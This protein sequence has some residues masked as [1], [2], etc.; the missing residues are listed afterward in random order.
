MKRK[1]LDIIK[2]KTGIT[3]DDLDNDST[4][5]IKTKSP[6]YAL[7]ARARVIDNL[8]KEDEADISIQSCIDL[9]NPIKD[10][11]SLLPDSG[12]AQIIKDESLYRIKAASEALTELQTIERMLV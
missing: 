11:V 7:Q 10:K 2:D 8:P 1:T 4:A 12:I 9:I 3:N 5:Y 6:V